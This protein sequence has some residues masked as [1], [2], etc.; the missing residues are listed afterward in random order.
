MKITEAQLRHEFSTFRG[1]IADSDFWKLG[2]RSHKLILK[3]LDNCWKDAILPE[4]TLA[5]WTLEYQALLDE[6]IS[7]AELPSLRGPIC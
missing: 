3:T 2:I 4:E 6:Y 1:L 5:S 7:I